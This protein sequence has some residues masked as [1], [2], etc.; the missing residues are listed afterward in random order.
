[1]A[2]ALVE[3]TRTDGKGIGIDCGAPC[4]GPTNPAAPA[5]PEGTKTESLRM[6]F[7][8]SET[9]EN[10]LPAETELLGQRLITGNIMGVHVVEKTTALPDHDQQTTAGAVVFLVVLKMGGEV[11]DALGEKRDLH[12]GG[13]CVLVVQTE[14]LDRFGLNF[15]SKLFQLGR[16]K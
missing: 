7:I 5:G 11:V 14:A 13:P 12:I 1:M 8:R 10:Q 3:I 2:E 4:V 9:T 15:H 6:E 16:A